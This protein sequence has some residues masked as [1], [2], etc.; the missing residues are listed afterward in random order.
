MEEGQIYQRW[1]EGHLK[2]WIALGVVALLVMF[3]T[4]ILIKQRWQDE[5]Y[6]FEACQE[7]LRLDCDPSLVWMVA[8]WVDVNGSALTVASKEDR[9]AMTAEE[10]KGLILSIRP[11]PMSLENGWYLGRGGET[12]TIDVKTAK[13]A[14]VSLFIITQTN[15]GENRVKIADMRH[16]SDTELQ[17]TYR[18]PKGLSATLEAVA[19]AGDGTEE[20]SS[21]RIASE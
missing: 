8:G 9:N 6:R 10:G 18:L 20:S 1:P 21:V 7:H 17:S 3:S 19:T 5:A 13:A 12:V 16:L 14:D 2:V 15:E 11:R 4:P